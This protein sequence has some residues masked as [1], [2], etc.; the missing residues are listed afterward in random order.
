MASR[1]KKL[2]IQNFQTK[3]PLRTTKRP[4]IQSQLSFDFLFFRGT[5]FLRCYASVRFDR[6]WYALYVMN[7]RYGFKSEM[8]KIKKWRF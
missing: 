3:M 1:I 2:K 7:N 6:I 4:L 8:I 5:G